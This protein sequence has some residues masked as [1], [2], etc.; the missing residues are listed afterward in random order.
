[1]NMHGPHLCYTFMDYGCQIFLD[2]LSEEDSA[3]LLLRTY[4]SAF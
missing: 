1:M 2:T 4:F 3:E